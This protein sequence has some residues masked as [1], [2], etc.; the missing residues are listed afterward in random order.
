MLQWCADVGFYAKAAN[1]VLPVGEGRVISLH[2][3]TAAMREVGRNAARGCDVYVARLPRTPGVCYAARFSKPCQHCQDSMRKVGVRRV[4]YTL[5]SP[6][7]TIAWA[8][9]DL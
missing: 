8:H 1:K 2:A 7:G 3:E 9:I 4:W 5:D 6:P